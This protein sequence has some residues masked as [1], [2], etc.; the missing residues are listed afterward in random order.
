MTLLIAG[1][2]PAESASTNTAVETDLRGAM[3]VYL[4]QG[5]DEQAALKR[6]ARDRGVS[7]SEVYRE[8]QREPDRRK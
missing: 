8:W 1:A 2:D 4:G 3:A 6:V 7:K 5:L